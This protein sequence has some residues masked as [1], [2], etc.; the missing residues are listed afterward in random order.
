MQRGCVMADHFKSQVKLKNHNWTTGYCTVL[1]VLPFLLEHNTF[2][3]PEPL[4]VL[5]L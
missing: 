3:K 5:K 2:S 1:L 4:G